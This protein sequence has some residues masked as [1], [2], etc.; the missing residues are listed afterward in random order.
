MDSQNWYEH[1]RCSV[2]CMQMVSKIFLGNWILP[3]GFK[4][5][6]HIIRPACHLAV[7]WLE[8]SFPFDE[9][10]DVDDNHD[11]NRYRCYD[12]N[13]QEPNANPRVH[14]T[15]AEE[16]E[17]TAKEPPT[18]GINTKVYDLAKLLKPVILS[19]YDN[20]VLLRNWI[21]LLVP[22]VRDKEI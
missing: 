22:K 14:P 4:G 15:A 9:Q 7:F 16:K 10:N 11:I 18:I 3:C 8:I 13:S 12:R 1:K 20:C 5:W 19:L 6:S 17:E 2:K 21:V